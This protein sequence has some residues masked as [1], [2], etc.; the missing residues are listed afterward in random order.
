MVTE[1]LSAI[2]LMPRRIPWFHG[3]NRKHECFGDQLHLVLDEQGPY[4][5]M[6]TRFPKFQKLVGK[7]I[8]VK[9]RKVTAI[10]TDLLL[11]TDSLFEKHSIPHWINSG[12]LLGAWREGSVVP[13]DNDGDM[14]IRAQDAEK[15]LGLKAEIEA[16]GYLF[17]ANKRGPTYKMYIKSKEKPK[18]MVEVCSMH[19]HNVTLD[20]GTPETLWTYHPLMVEAVERR[21]NRIYETDKSNEI[22]A[23]RYHQRQKSKI[24]IDNQYLE[25]E[26][27][28]IQRLP[29]AGST[30]AAP[31]RP[32][33]TLQR[34][35]GT[36]GLSQGLIS[37]ACQWTD[38][39]YLFK[40][41][42]KQESRL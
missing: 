19:P 40:V 15:V 38:G 9:S 27:F 41:S 23:H 21:V 13:W 29:F 4:T 1:L 20:D 33:I 37:C 39:D 26:I 11:F 16:A 17:D 35:Y 28:P 24:Y 31:C 36:A 10:L 14:M 8:R 30:I 5:I 12:T 25:S 7:R 22:G 3:K 42:I 2:G 6:E 18:I 34:D 32:D